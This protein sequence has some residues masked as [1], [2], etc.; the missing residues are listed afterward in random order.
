MNLIASIVSAV[1]TVYSTVKA[2]TR[3][4]MAKRALAKD[5]A[6]AQAEKQKQNENLNRPN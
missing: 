1:K 2:R 6:K 3:A 5:D 4:V